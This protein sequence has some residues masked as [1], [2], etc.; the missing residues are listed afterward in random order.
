MDA[1]EREDRK[2]R[3]YKRYAAY[4]IIILCL[5][6]FFLC[7]NGFIAGLTAD[8]KSLLFDWLGKTNKWS[9]TYGSESLVHSMDDLSALAGRLFISLFS[10]I[11]G[12]YLFIRKKYR[13]LYTYFFVVIGAGVLHVFLKNYY[14]G[15]PWYNW[16]NLFDTNGKEFPS[17]H[18]LMSIVFYFT[19]ARLIYRSNADRKVNRY[20]MTIALILSFSIGIAQIIKGAHSPNEIIAGWAIGFAWVTTAWLLDHFI[21]KKIYIRKHAE[22]I[23]LKE[24]ETPAS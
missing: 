14:G 6:I 7:T 10:L 9:G 5:Y 3:K 11:F 19:I 17:G 15:E 8:Y 12:G 24:S 21:R 4:S 1:V 16:L 2:S 23:K 20:L 18:A 13:T 22:K